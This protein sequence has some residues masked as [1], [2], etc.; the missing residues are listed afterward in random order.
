VVVIWGDD[1][2]R[3]GPWGVRV[4]GQDLAVILVV[5]KGI[6]KREPVWL[7]LFY[8]LRIL[9]WVAVVRWKLVNMFWVWVRAVN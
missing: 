1:G 2:V 7:A 4:F 9:V 8:C 6:S 3:G 5:L